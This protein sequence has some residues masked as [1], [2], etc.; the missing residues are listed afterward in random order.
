MQA[1]KSGTVHLPVPTGRIA[2]DFLRLAGA[3]VVVGLTFA[4]VASAVVIL[5]TSAA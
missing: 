4:A 5:I 3:S 1:T 2:A